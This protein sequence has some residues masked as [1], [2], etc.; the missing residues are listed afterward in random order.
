MKLL[1]PLLA[2]IALLL[3]GCVAPTSQNASSTPAKL[4]LS[5]FSVDTLDPVPGETII[6]TVT[7]QN[8]GD[9]PGSAVV[10]LSS[11]GAKHGEV[12]ATV[13]G[14]ANVTKYIE[15]SLAKAGKALVRATL[16]EEEKAVTVT[17]RA[18]FIEGVSWSTDACQGDTMKFRVNLVN[19]GDGSAEAVGVLVEVY[20]GESLIGSA[21]QEVRDVQPGK[22]ATSILSITSIDLCW[23]AEPHAAQVTVTPPSQEPILSSRTI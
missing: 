16:G 12:S 11:G 21:S 18:P 5:G 10:V 2:T 19:S 6:A 23:G 1:P 9:L 8:A 17:V 13:A 20:S 15:F 22:T 4:S 3:A 14:G 7:I